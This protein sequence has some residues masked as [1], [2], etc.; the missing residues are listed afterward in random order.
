MKV[1]V[2]APS[3]SRK[4][5]GLFFSVR[6]LTQSMMP[7]GVHNTVYGFHDE[8]SME[9]LDAWKPLC[10]RAFARRGPVFFPIAHTMKKAVLEST[11]DILHSHGLWLYPS[12]VASAAQRKLRIP[13]VVSPHGMLEPWAIQFSWW[14]KKM[15]ACLYENRHLRTASCVHAL[16]ESEYRSIRAYGLTNPV[17]IIPNGVDLPENIPAQ[18]E[19]STQKGKKQLLFLAR[20]HPKKGLSELIQAWAMDKPRT[21]E[22][23]IAG[24]D[25]GGHECNLIRMVADRD[26]ADSVHFIGPVFGSAK[27]RVLRSADAFILPSHSEGFPL[28]VLEAW[29]YALPVIMTTQCNIPDG[30]RENAAIEIQPEVHSIRNGLDSLFSMSDSDRKTLGLQGRRLVE[31]NYAWPKLALQMIEVYRWCLGRTSE[32]D[33]MRLS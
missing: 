32:P 13:Y 3:L 1:A 14:K 26:M 30:F 19:H 8:Y 28:S 16:C 5:G 11:F 24:W 15:A 27:D 9:D 25:D 20:I 31:T 22:L 4:A 6:G 10:V 7:F 18:R 21:W 17:A 23:L 2:V 12:F 33:C 29:S